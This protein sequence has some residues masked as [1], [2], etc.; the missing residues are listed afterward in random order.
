M[1]RRWR[2]RNKLLLGLGLVVGCVGTL[3]AGTAYGLSS[4]R[5]TMKTT[6]SKLAELL[7]LD[8]L[9]ADAAAIV[10]VPA[11]PKAGDPIEADQVTTARDRLARSKETFAVYK[12]QF[13]DTV[14]RAEAPVA[15]RA[16]HA[17]AVAA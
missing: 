8:K 12:S 9:K 6:D 5:G 15:S 16:P 3:I 4:Y 14:R 1:A 13:E 11:A 2:L 10:A 17:I 7:T